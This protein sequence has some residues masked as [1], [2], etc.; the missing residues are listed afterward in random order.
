V[1]AFCSHPFCFFVLSLRR[2]LWSSSAPWACLLPRI[3]RGLEWVLLCEPRAPNCV[4]LL[5]GMSTRPPRR[6]PPRAALPRTPCPHARP[7]T[8]ASVRA[9]ARFTRA[10]R[11]LA[12]RTRTR[13]RKVFDHAHLKKWRFRNAP[14][15]VRKTIRRR[16]GVPSFS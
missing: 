14:L 5:C 12:F 10:P 7:V 16:G 11:A 2:R 13:P 1:D 15:Y 4:L 9:P 6:P 3:T 8:G